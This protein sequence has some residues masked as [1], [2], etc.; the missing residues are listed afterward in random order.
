MNAMRQAA[1]DRAG[2]T[3]EA[4]SHPATQAG[5][6]QAVPKGDWLWCKLM[7]FCKKR[8][9][10]PA[11]FDDLF[12]IV[13]VARSLAATQ[14]SAAPGD[15]QGGVTDREQNLIDGIR[16][17]CDH[18]GI[19]DMRLPPPFGQVEGEIAV[20]ESSILA[21]VEGWQRQHGLLA[22]PA[23][24]EPLDWLELCNARRLA[25]PG[26]AIAARQQEVEI[27]DQIDA[28]A[29]AVR[30][31][32]GGW[33]DSSDPKAAIEK[34]RQARILIRAILEAPAAPTSQPNAAA[35]EQQA[36][37]RWVPVE[38]T[39]AMIEAGAKA[40]PERESVWAAYLAAAPK[41]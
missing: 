18:A 33:V 2:E 10:A 12:A 1:M 38:P 6:L 11:N 5:A 15:G 24:T 36:G 16:R 39:P 17:Q 28:I 31:V 34:G 37:W 3:G 21:A 25:A 19:N 20:R 9:F 32:Y 8:G 26:A 7:D 30:S 41:P 27:E 22:D 4:S 13:G 29:S 23:N 40:D 14:P 35:Q